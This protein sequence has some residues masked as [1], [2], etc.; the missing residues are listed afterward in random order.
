MPSD[1]SATNGPLWQV[2]VPLTP[3]WPV[4]SSPAIGTDG[5]VYIGGGTDPYGLYAVQGAAGPA[6]SAW[7]LWR[8][9]NAHQANAGLP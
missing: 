4:T 7:P 8:R 1:T 2:Q 9:N 3:Y 5:M 6:N